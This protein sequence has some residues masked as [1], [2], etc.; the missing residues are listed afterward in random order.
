M[1][2]GSGRGLRILPP[3]G[4]ESLHRP[5]CSE[6]LNR[7]RYPGRHINTLWAGD[8]VLRLYITTVQDG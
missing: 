2:G 7:L 4:I 1:L 8:A 6:W 5:A 3:T